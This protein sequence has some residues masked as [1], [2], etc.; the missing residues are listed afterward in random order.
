MTIAHTSAKICRDALRRHKNITTAARTFVGS[1]TD[2][3]TDE[4]RV[5]LFVVLLSAAEITAYGL[6][7]MQEAIDGAVTPATVSICAIALIGCVADDRLA[8][9]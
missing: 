4:A 6:V 3:S 9:I 5:E 8:S 1:G 7:A 2:S